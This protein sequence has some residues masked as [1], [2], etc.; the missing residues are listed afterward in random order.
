[1]IISARVS[2]KSRKTITWIGCPFL[3]KQ[4][5][6]E[7]S[8]EQSRHLAL[9]KMSRWKCVVEHVQA[10]LGGFYS[11]NSRPDIFVK[12]GVIGLNLRGKKGT[13]KWSASVSVEWYLC[14]SWG[15]LICMKPMCT[16]LYYTWKGFFLPFLYPLDV[17]VLSFCPL[18]DHPQAKGVRIGLISALNLFHQNL[19]DSTQ[20]W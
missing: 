2:L 20:K 10:L 7:L 17:D 13:L 16:I 1:M 6:S 12:R 11:L 4:L 14:N 9:R 5:I 19:D 8:E 3:W 18:C 15:S